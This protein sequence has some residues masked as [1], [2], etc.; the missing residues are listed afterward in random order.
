M[1]KYSLKLCFFFYLISNVRFT[2]I[3]EG[4]LDELTLCVLSNIFMINR[5]YLNDSKNN[6]L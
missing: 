2:C 3:C 4:I 1:A 6:F 5:V